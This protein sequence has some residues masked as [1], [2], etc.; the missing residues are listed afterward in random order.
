VKRLLASGC[1]LALLAGCATPTVPS[2]AGPELAPGDGLL[3]VG[4]DRGESPVRWMVLSSRDAKASVRVNNVVADLSLYLYEVKAGRYCLDKYDAGVSVFRSKDPTKGLCVTVLPGRL[5]Y[6]GHITPAPSVG[7][8]TYAAGRPV[9]HYNGDVY[10]TH[11]Y[12]LLYQQLREGY[13]AIF[14][15]YADQLEQPVLNQI[16]YIGPP[17]ASEAH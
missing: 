5:A 8:V 2:D 16:E 10:Q 11:Q 17:V 1:I 9:V 13:P 12:E 15:R 4:F 6:Y 14:A 3:A 7:K